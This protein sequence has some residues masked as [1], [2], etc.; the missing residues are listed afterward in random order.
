MLPL[1]VVLWPALQLKEELPEKLL[2]VVRSTVRRCCTAGHREAVGTSW[3]E[4]CVPR[5]RAT[6]SAPVAFG[7]AVAE[8]LCP[9]PVEQANARAGWGHGGPEMFNLALK[10]HPEHQMFFMQGTVIG[11][12]VCCGHGVRR[13]LRLS[14]GLK[15]E[16][17]LKCP[18]EE[19]FAG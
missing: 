6:Y 7:A 9:V 17:A 5:G 10:R 15:A 2:E 1:S 14:P 8:W 13:I 18:A 12:S 11:W 3:Q 16:E 19:K 4:G